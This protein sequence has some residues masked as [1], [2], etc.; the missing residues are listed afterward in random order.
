MVS[1]D[2]FDALKTPG[3]NIY[4]FLRILNGDGS[5]FCAAKDRLY[6]E[7]K[8]IVEFL[9]TFTVLHRN[10]PLNFS[11]NMVLWLYGCCTRLTSVLMEPD[12]IF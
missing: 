9:D 12:A 4:F 1:E 6:L 10:E 2:V 8:C 3:I 11:K 5:I 7:L